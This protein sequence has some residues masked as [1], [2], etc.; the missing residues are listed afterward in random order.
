MGPGSAA[1]DTFVQPI[2]AVGAAGVV[3]IACT[4]VNDVGVGGSDSHRPQGVY[5]GMVEHRGPGG[6]V[7]CGFVQASVARGQVNGVKMLVLGLFRYGNVHNPTTRAE[8]ADVAVRQFGQK[9]AG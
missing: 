3:R 8:G 1:V 9:L 5:I 7:V 6:A 2:A 4:Q